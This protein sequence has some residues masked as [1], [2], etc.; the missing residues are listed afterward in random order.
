MNAVRCARQIALFMLMMSS[1]TFAQTRPTHALD[2]EWRLRLDRQDQGVNE[3]WHQAWP[4]QAIRLPG[5]LPGQGIGDP[6]TTETPWVGS[7]FDP[8]YFTAERY[9]P[10]REPGNIKVPFWL[11]PETYYR[12]VAWYQRE[13]E[14]PAEWRGRRVVLSLERPHWTTEVWLDERHLGTRESLSI[15]HEYDLGTELEPGRHR[16][17]IRVNNDLVVDV[18]ENSHSVS[19]HTQGNWN[20]IVGRI[21]LVATAP[22]YVES[23]DVYPQLEPRAVRVTGKIGRAAGA[24]RPEH[25]DVTVAGQGRVERWTVESDGRFSGLYRLPDDAALWDEFSP[26]LHEVEVRLESDDVRRVRFGL[27]EITA[28]SRQLRLNGRPIFIRG[29]LECAIFPATGHPPTDVDSWRRILTIAREHGLN[30]LRFHSWC[31]PEA[32][33]VAGDEM[34]FYFQIE[35]ASWPNQSTGVGEGKPVDRWLEEETQR[36]LR[37]YGNHPSFVL[38]ASGNEPGGPEAGRDAYLSEWLKRRR[39]EDSRRL[40]TSGAGWPML[41]E[42]Q[43]HV[44]SDPRIQQW[45]AGL[46]SRINGRPP[47]TLTDYRE[48]IQK[49]EV[50]VISHEIGQWCVFPDFDEMSRYTGYLKPRN[51]EIFQ[52]TLERNGLGHLARE[53]LYASGKLQA[54]CYKEDIE[55]ALRTPQM[56]GFQLLDLHDFPGQGTAL[57]GVLSPFWES[58]G[59]ISAEAFRRFCNSTVPLARL[60]RRVFTQSDVL[61]AVCQVAHFGAGPRLAA[62]G[63]TLRSVEGHVVA[64]GSFA[65][66]TLEVGLNEVGRVEQSLAGVPAPAQYCLEVAIPGTEF[67]NDWDI[68]VYPDQ[69]DAP[70]GDVL[71]AGQWD[72]AVAAQLQG[73]GT[74]L[75]TLSPDQVRNDPDA[76]VHLG[77]SS[78][79]WNTSWT[80]RQAPTT[81]GLLCDPAHPA[82]AAFPTEGYSN[83]QWWYVLQQAAAL[84]LDRMPAGLEPVVRVIDDWFT[85]RPLGLI[86]EARVGRGR[87]IVTGLDLREPTDPVRRQLRASLL[88]YAGSRSF[89][90]RTQITPEQVQGLL[91]AH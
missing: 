87:L 14:V 58:K 35:A 66:R 42:N 9:A 51:F 53:F 5:S 69:P 21:E 60:E 83:W 40:F 62:P 70:A 50:P 84:P 63:W 19:D 20:G 17:T 78:I 77:F 89:A 91:R 52:A 67:A 55:S 47:E 48:F 75:L 4:G 71:V 43:Y 61:T 25:V 72:E 13:I 2:G 65:E 44:H 24:G 74:V 90:P 68:W 3:G 18:G 73:G 11:Q 39:Q 76:P 31:P 23:V 46:T 56:A 45:G 54:L 15:P 1:L 8:S 10:Y 81:L 86:L 64:E 34:G 37:T 57:V 12:G 88:A 80:N 16:L 59:Y 38:M 28:E 22:Q 30:S 85:S 82:L 33:F 32:A 41:P 27:R 26:A 7:L 6:V 29:T 49:A 36:I 79:F